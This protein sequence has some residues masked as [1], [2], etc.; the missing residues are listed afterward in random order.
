MD[1]MDDILEKFMADHKDVFDEA[2]WCLIMAACNDLD[3]PEDV[4][5]AITRFLKVLRDGK[6]DPDVAIDAINALNVPKK[7]EPTPA[8]NDISQEE[9]TS[10]VNVLN[11]MR[12][13]R[14]ENAS[15]KQ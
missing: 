8:S 3:G 10:F 12:K 7:E 9:L 11:K 13:K 14:E 6:V 4:K 15:E 5:K 2:K 1:E